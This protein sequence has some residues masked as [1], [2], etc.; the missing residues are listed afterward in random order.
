[1]SVICT[2]VTESTNGLDPEDVSLLQARI[3]LEEI[4]LGKGSLKLSAWGKNL[5]D[6]QCWDVALTSTNSQQWADPRSY[7]LEATYEF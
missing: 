5:T 2:A 1:L 6:E 4:P 7:G 3:S